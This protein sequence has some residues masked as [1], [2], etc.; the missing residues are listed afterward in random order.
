MF[1]FYNECP[2][3]ININADE[4][5]DNNTDQK[6]LL[7]LI[8][9]DDLLGL[10]DFYEDMVSL[11][12]NNNFKK[13]IFAI[14][15]DAKDILTDFENDDYVFQDL[16]I[17]LSHLKG[18]TKDDLQL[19]I[20]PFNDMDDLKWFGLLYHKTKLIEYCIDGKIIGCNYISK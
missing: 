15:H 14:I 4:L 13:G 16:N 20:I 12:L 9:N 1:D 5:I 19:L 7:D 18:M 3:P 8:N 17:D 10:K 2:F 11:F 6:Y